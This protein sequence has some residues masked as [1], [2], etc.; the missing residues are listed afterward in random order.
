MDSTRHHHQRTI[1]SRGPAQAAATSRARAPRTRA[2]ETRRARM[3]AGKRAGTYARA[4]ARS[5]PHPRPR[6]RP[7]SHKPKHTNKLVHPRSLL[8]L[9]P[10]RKNLGI[11]QPI[12]LINQGVNGHT[13][14][15]RLGY[16]TPEGTADWFLPPGIARRPA[17]IAS[18]ARTCRSRWLRGGASRPG[19]SGGPRGRRGQG[20][21]PMAHMRESV[22]GLAR[23]RYFRECTADPHSSSFSSSSCPLPPLLLMSSS[24]SRSHPEEP[25]PPPWSPLSTSLRPAP[26]LLIIID[27]SM[28]VHYKKEMGRCLNLIDHSAGAIPI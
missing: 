25:F 6:P 19:R 1:V 27:P 8:A 11:P 17:S 18:A 21:S 14:W 26:D 3:Q 24:R 12:Y 20:G 4:R 23:P 16:Y 7:H 28:T 15:R 22:Q 9:S 10:C 13:T 2:H 5:Y